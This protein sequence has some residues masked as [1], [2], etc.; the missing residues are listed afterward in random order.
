MDVEFKTIKRFLESCLE[1]PDLRHV[2][3]NYINNLGSSTWFSVDSL[4]KLQ[5][6]PIVLTHGDLGPT[7]ILTNPKGNITA[8]VDWDNSLFLPF[9]WDFYGVELFFGDL[10]VK[11][12]GTFAF[13]N[14]KAR[15]ELEESFWT[16]FWDNAPREIISNKPKF[17][18]AL[19]ISRGVGV[20]WQYIEPD[21]GVASF[22][23]NFGHYLPIVKTLLLAEYALQ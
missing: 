18:K 12:D 17:Q 23:K 9:G 7:N 11:E 5:D 14:K 16:T 2:V 22:L 13:V 8:V 21:Q 20:L 4:D 6:L 1:L 10:S 15:A 19:R 3:Q